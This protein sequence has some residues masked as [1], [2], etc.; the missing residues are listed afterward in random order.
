[1]SFEG[2]VYSKCQHGRCNAAMSYEEVDCVYSKCQHGK[3]Q[4]LTV[5]PISFKA[6][7]GKALI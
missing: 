6:I 2:I 5:L 3:C 1:M 4:R 7:K